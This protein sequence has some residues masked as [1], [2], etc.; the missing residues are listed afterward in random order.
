MSAAADETE[1]DVRLELRELG[2]DEV[3]ESVVS[4]SPDSSDVS[5]E[6]E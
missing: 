5:S 4:P 3:E 6:S 1:D 2:E